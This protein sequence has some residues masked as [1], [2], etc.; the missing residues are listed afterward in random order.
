[1]RSG[2]AAYAPAV[3]WSWLRRLVRSFDRDA[4]RR[5]HDTPFP[6]AWESYLTEQPFVARLPIA[7]H[8]ELRHV[9]RVLVEE[10]SWEGCGG[11]TITAETQVVVAAHAARLLL[12]MPHAYYRNVT[13]ILVYPTSF[14]NPGTAG[15]PSARHGEAWLRGPVVLAWD[16]V[17]SGARNPSDGRNLVLHE[18]AHKLDFLDDYGNGTPPLH[19]RD[20]YAAWKRIMSA[21][22]AELQQDVAEGRRSTLDP[23]GATNP[24]EFFAVATETFFEKPVQL[25]RRHAGLYTLLMD[26]YG[27]DPA[28]AFD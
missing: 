17:Q 5:V 13:S 20:Q 7:Q 2:R 6:S 11:L 9:L 15:D 23:Y 25:R 21:E 26:Y 14:V 10:K 16:Q 1:M 18:F 28:A 8:S 19:A 24:A 4:R 3:P 22:Y 12:G 27:Q